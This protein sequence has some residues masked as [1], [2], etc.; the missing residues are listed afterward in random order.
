MWKTQQWPQDWK[1]SVFTPIPQDCTLSPCLFN[2]YAEHI[3]RNPGLGEAQAGIKITG[4]NINDLRYAD[5]LYSRKQRT[6][7]PLDESDRGE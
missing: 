2:L 1:R 5:D 7:E 4:R 6:K 3:M